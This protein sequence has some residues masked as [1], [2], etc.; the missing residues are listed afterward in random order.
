MEDY[1]DKYALLIFK[2]LTNKLL[3]SK[4]S[5]SFLKYL[6][7]RRD[8]RLRFLITRF[9]NNSLTPEKLIDALDEL[10]EKESSR[11][12]NALFANHSLEVGKKISK[13]ER[14]QKSLNYI[15]LTYG[16]IDF[17]SFRSIL[18]KC[19]RGKN[20]KVFYDLGSGKY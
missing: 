5:V 11:C 16:E 17:V 8:E 14:Q 10:V 9:L 13:E 1:H 3:F 15:N 12:F 4:N 7:F 2:E 18:S 19:C 20:F 6:L